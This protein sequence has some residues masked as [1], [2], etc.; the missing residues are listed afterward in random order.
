MLAKMRIIVIQKWDGPCCFECYANLTINPPVPCQ[1]SCG[2][3]NYQMKTIKCAKVANPKLATVF[4]LNTLYDFPFLE[5]HEKFLKANA[6]MI[7]VNWKLVAI[8]N[9]DGIPG[10]NVFDFG[11]KVGCDLWIGF[12]K[13]LAKSGVVDGL[14]D[15]KSNV[16]P[17][18]N[19][20][21]SFWQICKHNNGGGSTWSESCGIISNKTAL[22][23]NNGKKWC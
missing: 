2:G 20:T 17:S 23:Y 4:Y 12:I 14:F 8:K 6:D 15:D 13:E 22:N 11:Q 10:V 5:L 21:G 3:E 16:F 9:D 1:P 19:V 18:W 7:D